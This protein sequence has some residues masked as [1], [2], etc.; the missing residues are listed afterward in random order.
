VDKGDNEKKLR[1]KAHGRKKESGGCDSIPNR[2][3][4]NER[5]SVV[6]EKARL[7]D[8]EAGLLREQGQEDV[9]L[10]LVDRKSQF[11]LMTKPRSREPDD[12]AVG[13]LS[14]F[15]RCQSKIV[16]TITFDSSEEFARHDLVTRYF[17]ASCYFAARGCPWERGLNEHTKGLVRQFFP[18]GSDLSSLRECDLRPVEDLLNGRPRRALEFK[19]PQDVYN[20]PPSNGEIANVISRFC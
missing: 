7:G 15:L 18:K 10:V 12:V 8:W 20:K 11:T 1:G 6:E 9:I 13:I 3:D 19:T 5:P 16:H 17:G 4:I 14:C 2:V